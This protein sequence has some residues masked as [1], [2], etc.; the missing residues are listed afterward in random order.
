MSSLEVKM[1]ESLPR[2]WAELPYPSYLRSPPE[3]RL[4]GEQEQSPVSLEEAKGLLEG[5]EKR[6]T[7]DRVLDGDL[8]HPSPCRSFSWMTK[9]VPLE[10]KL[11]GRDHIMLGRECW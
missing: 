9:H 10:L 8:N 11:E 3:G 4:P 7:E 2:G 5:Q 6:T 1:K